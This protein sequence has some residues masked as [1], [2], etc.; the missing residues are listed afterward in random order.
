[1]PVY[2]DFDT[3]KAKVKDSNWHF[4]WFKDKVCTNK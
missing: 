4:E 1:M 3:F 2:A